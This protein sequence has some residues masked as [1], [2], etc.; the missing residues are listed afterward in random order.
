[1]TMMFDATE[2]ATPALPRRELDI[3]EYWE[4]ESHDL[5]GRHEVRP[6]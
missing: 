5:H 4:P 1:M 3:L 2:F 6:E